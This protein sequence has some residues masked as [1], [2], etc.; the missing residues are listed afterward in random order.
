M[1]IREKGRNM[2]MW[3]NIYACFAQKNYIKAN[4]V[5]SSYT[6]YGFKSVS[7]SYGR[8]GT[9]TISI[10]I[11]KLMVFERRMRGTVIQTTLTPVSS[12]A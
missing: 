9:Q 12:N 10:K 5:I 8:R 4:T 6:N 3:Q 1:C 2:C 7:K 11:K